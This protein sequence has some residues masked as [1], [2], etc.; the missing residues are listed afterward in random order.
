MDAKLARSIYSR[1]S[2]LMGC[3]AIMFD[4]RARYNRANLLE[5]EAGRK[6]VKTVKTV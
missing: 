3:K 4:K 5:K 2:G 6:T 1:C